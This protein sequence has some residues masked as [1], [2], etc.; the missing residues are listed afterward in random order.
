MKENIINVL[1]KKEAEIDRDFEVKVEISKQVKKLG[2]CQ[3]LFNREGESP[4]IIQ[5][6]KKE[7]SDKIKYSTKVQLPKLGTYYFF[8]ILEIDG[9]KV[10]IK[11]SRATDKPFF[12]KPE[13]ESPYWSVLVTQQDLG[14]PDWAKD[15]IVY[16]I[17]VDRFNKAE[18]YGSGKEPGRNYRIWGEMPDWRRNAKGEFHNNDFFCGNIKGIIEKIP[19]FNS[20]GVGILYLSPI[21]EC[22]YR[23]ERY[24]STNHMKID[25]DAGTFED[26]K[27]L[28]EKANENGIKVILDIALNH[29]SSDN[30]I[31]QEALKNPNSKYR[32]WFYIDDQGN[33][34]YWYGEFKDMP[35]FNQNNP[36]FQ[37]YAYGDNR[38][39]YTFASYV[40]G[41]RLD[42]AES[43]Q[44][45][46]LEGIKK[47]ANHYGK[48][49]IIGE[50]WHLAPQEVLKRGIDGV[51]NYPLTE[52][53]LRFVADQDDKCLV[54]TL[55]VLEKYYPQS[56]RD[57]SLTSLSTH[58]IIRVITILSGKMRREKPD[59]IWE[60]DKDGSR[61]HVIKNGRR[62][63]L[64]DDFRQFQFE[65][66]KLSLEE[67]E[68]AISKLKVAM[69]LQYFLSG[70]PC[71][72][73]GD[74]IGMHGG[75]DPF[76]RKCFP[77][78]EEE[79]D[80]QFLRFVQELGKIRNLYKGQGYEPKTLYHEKGL[81]A[82]ERGG[83]ENEIFVATN[84]SE[85]PRDIWI[86]EKFKK[87][88]ESSKIFSLNANAEE[89]YLLPDGGLIILK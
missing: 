57:I 81:Y 63:F 24:A 55:N 86:P 59:R 39:I 21:N 3:V 49:L 27:E 31:F 82:F 67:Y 25:P 61:W 36:D 89:E 62:A 22:L 11:I 72:Y 69:I 47:R 26:L 33:Y 17:F 43:L 71:I 18:G 87:N 40:D 45:F 8:F 84:S 48:H 14:T 65:N 10:A 29:C 1:V 13:E 46:F 12:L 73:Y 7:E 2:N 9:K 42:L 44:P 75:K 30:P 58:D 53:I 19:Y 6:M 88:L 37:Q 4:S 28:H 66:D 85:Y 70:N 76:N 56:A 23:Y 34:Q 74:E 83:K 78:N 5:Q 35:I 32:S 15:K 38:V 77:K 16:Q 51:T 20:L 54:D 41:F 79:M 80:L 60:I 50:Y 68:K 52:G 64:V